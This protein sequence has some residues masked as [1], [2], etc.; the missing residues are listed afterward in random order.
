MKVLTDLPEKTM[1]RTNAT[2]RIGRVGHKALACGICQLHLTAGR[3]RRSL[4]MAQTFAGHQTGMRAWINLSVAL[5][6]L[7]LPF[8]ATTQESVSKTQTSGK[9]LV[10][11]TGDVSKDLRNPVTDDPAYVIGPADVLDISVWKEPEVSRTVPVRPDGNISLPLLNDVHAAGLTPTQLA[12]Q[13][14]GRLNKYVTNPQV[15][16]I[17]TVINSQ[18]I[19]ILGEVVRAGAYPLLPGMTVLQALSSAG[20]FT[21]FANTKDICL[22]REEN[23]KHMKYLFNYKDVINGD[24]SEQN[25]ALKAGDT[26][27][28]P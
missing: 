18:R 7:F 9:A 3:V 1:R 16:V 24:K 22:L 6:L 15:T 13:I 26:I 25:T 5:L 4:P 21:Q 28:V 8:A 14:T 17:I 11:R 23:G 10:S 27:V 2:A 19:Y 12:A 20:G